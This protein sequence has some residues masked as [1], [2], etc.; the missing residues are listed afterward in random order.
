M[1]HV[2][3]FGAEGSLWNYHSDGVVEYLDACKMLHVV[4]SGAELFRVMMCVTCEII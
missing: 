4:G 2:A 3:G 1:L